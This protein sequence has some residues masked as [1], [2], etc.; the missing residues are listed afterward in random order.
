VGAQVGA[1]QFDVPERPVRRV[2]RDRRELKTLT[3]VAC[4]VRRTDR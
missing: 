4:E 3:R 2:L 1:Q